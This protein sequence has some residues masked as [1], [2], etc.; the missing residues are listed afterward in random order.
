M[1]GLYDL[2][3]ILR[4]VTIFSLPESNPSRITDIWQSIVFLATIVIPIGWTFGFFMMTNER[5]TFELRTA[6]LNMRKMAMFDFLTGAYSRR[7][8]TDLIQ[9]E[10]KQSLRNE[11]PMVLLMLDVDHFKNFNDSHGHL[12]GD[13]MLCQIVKTCHDNLRPGDIIGRWGGEEFSIL[14]PNTDLDYGVQVAERLRCAVAN[15]SVPLGIVDVKPTV[16]IGVTHWK[17]SDKNW[18][19]MVQRADHALYDAKRNGR[20]R[21][22]IVSSRANISQ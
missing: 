19:D 6:E 7:A 21:V 18:D 13:E 14:L 16:S 20:N 2:V 1:F 17:N 3:L 10:Y 12:V 15:L 22:E 11:Q 4:V 8:Y 9:I 5:L